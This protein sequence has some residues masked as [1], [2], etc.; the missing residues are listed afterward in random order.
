[1]SSYYDYYSSVSNLLLS[2]NS[3]IIKDVFE[4][5][6]IIKTLITYDIDT[7]IKTF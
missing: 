6:H 7:V 5:V 1:M 3:I 4:D 2:L